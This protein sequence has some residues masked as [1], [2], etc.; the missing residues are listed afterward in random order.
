MDRSRYRTVVVRFGGISLSELDVR[1]IIMDDDGS[2]WWGR[3]GARIARGRIDEIR[4]QRDDE[5]VSVFFLCGK[6]L[7]LAEVTDC[8]H[9]VTGRDLAGAP[10][11]CSETES[12]P[13]AWFKLDGI[14]VL[15][16]SDA[17]AN[18]RLE[19][20][21][22]PLSTIPSSS[23][24]PISYVTVAIDC[25]ND[26]RGRTLQTHTVPWLKCHRAARPSSAQGQ[27]RPTD[28]AEV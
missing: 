15:A 26:W 17:V 4:A 2:V 22:K 1:P 12:K 13:G 9:I 14:A 19:S 24:N 3:R 10:S 8:Q 28:P 20:T 11:M 5:S 7:V 16:D 27:T 25:L 21:T 6:L 23:Q 18:V